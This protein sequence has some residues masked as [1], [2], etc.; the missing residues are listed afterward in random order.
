MKMNKFQKDL[1]ILYWLK[2]RPITYDF[3]QLIFHTSFLQEEYV[4]QGLHLSLMKT[5]FF[6]IDIQ[7]ILLKLINDPLNDINIIRFIDA[8]Q[9][10][11]KVNNHIN[12]YFLAIISL[13]EI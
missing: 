2:F 4:A 6:Q 5:I 7:K 1:N 13:I 12:I 10:I 9:D 3:D 8:N 11:I